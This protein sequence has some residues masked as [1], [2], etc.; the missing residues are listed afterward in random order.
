VNVHFEVWRWPAGGA[1]A[2]PWGENVCPPVFPVSGHPKDPQHN[3]DVFA[4]SDLSEAMDCLAAWRE[5]EPNVEVRV[6]K[7]TTEV[8][9]G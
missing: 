8:L 9:R 7:I 2:V 5:A 1:P 6:V 3:D 4:V